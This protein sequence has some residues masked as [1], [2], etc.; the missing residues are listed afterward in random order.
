MKGF[1]LV[2]LVC[3]NIRSE[4][5]NLPT[6]QASMKYWIFTLIYCTLQVDINNIVN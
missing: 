3:V 1:I 4:F 5:V 6:R 2:D